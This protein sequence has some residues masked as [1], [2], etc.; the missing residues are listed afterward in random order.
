MRKIFILVLLCIFTIFNLAVFALARQTPVE[1]TFI[2]KY[3]QPRD[4]RIYI[5]PNNKNTA[6]MKRACMQWSKATNNRIIFKYV[7]SPMAA[8]IKVVYVDKTNN[9]NYP[10]ALG[11][12]GPKFTAGGGKTIIRASVIIADYT[13]DGTLIG[14]DLKFIVMQHELG[15]A[16]G[17]NHSKNPN[18]IMFLGADI[19]QKITD[20]EI[21][22]LAKRYGWK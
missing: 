10:T 1:P 19:K 14:D 18:S 6:L 4:I 16:L 15:H 17:L 9:K 12:G 11:L 8:N 20:E 21:K 3:S 13:K 5:P 7:N 2:G 22:I